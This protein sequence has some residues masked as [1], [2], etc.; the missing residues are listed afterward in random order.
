MN[1]KEDYHIYSHTN[2]TITTLGDFIGEDDSLGIGFNIYNLL[3]YKDE[4]DN[5]NIDNLINLYSKEELSKFNSL[6]QEIK[7]N[8]KN[9]VQDKKPNNVNSNVGFITPLHVTTLQTLIKDNSYISYTP[10]NTNKYFLD[11]LYNDDIKNLFKKFLYRV[12]NETDYKV[13]IN[14]SLRTVTEQQRQKELGNSASDFSYHMIGLAIDIR[15]ENRTTPSI[16]ITKSSLNTDWIKSGVVKIANQLNLGWG[17]TFSNVN[18]DPV[19][20]E[21]KYFFKVDVKKFL[22]SNGVISE[23]STVSVEDQINTNKDNDKYFDLPLK[24]GTVLNLPLKDIDRDV[25]STETNQVINS[26]DY[27]CF[28]AKELVGLLSDV[29]YK[30]TF[31]PKNQSFTGD[32]KQIFPYI[33]VW[34]WSRSLSISSLKPVNDSTQY[35]HQILNI[36]PYILNLNTTVSENGGNFS[37]NLSSITADI[38]YTGKE[39]IKNWSVKE[40]S[41]KVSQTNKNNYVNQGHLHY[42]EDNELKRNRMYFDKIIQTNDIVFIR[43]EKLELED[44]RTNFDELETIS[45]N[46]LP[47]QIFDM[48]ALVDDIQTTNQFEN[49][50]ANISVSGRDL[51]KLLI[52]DGVYFYPTEATSDGIFANTGATNTRLKR[53][54]PSGEYLGRFQSANKTIAKSLK[55]LINNLGSIEICPGSLFDGYANSLANKNSTQVIDKRSRSFLL[56]IDADN[57]KSKKQEENAI[58][59]DSIIDKINRVRNVNKI[60]SGSTIEVFNAIKIFLQDRITN[61][62]IVIIGQK[63]ISWKNTDQGIIYNNKLPYTLFNIFIKSNRIWIDKKDRQIFNIALLSITEYLESIYNKTNKQNLDESSLTIF[64]YLSYDSSQGKIEDYFEAKIDFNNII[65][66]LNTYIL[67]DNNM[68][69]DVIDINNLKNSYNIIQAKGDFIKLGI[70]ST[71]FQDLNDLEKDVFNDIYNLILNENDIQKPD[72]QSGLLA[73][74]WQII[75]LVIDDSVAD[76]RLT[77]SSIG[78]ENGSLLNAIRKICQDPFC[79]FYTD[80]Y[81]SQFYFIV[82]KKPFDKESILSILEGRAIFENL[83]DNNKS[84]T[85]ES[86]IF[87]TVLPV[88][89]DS[90]TIVKQRLIIDI[91]ESD[92]ISDSLK[93]SNEVYSWYK[94]QLANLTTGTSTDMAFA[95]LKAIYFNEF[96]DMYGSKPL[97]LTTSYIPYSPIIDKNKSLPTAYFIRQGVYDLKY[98][99]ESHAHLPFTR[100]GS[101]VMNG[102]RRI[103]K[104]NF[105]R[106]KSTNEIFYVDAVNNSYSI[107]NSSIDRTT[108]IQ[109][110]R[111]MVERFIKGVEINIDNN[112]KAANSKKINF[113]YF[114]ICDLSI[115]ESIFTN[116]NSNPTDF[117]KASTGNWKV[118]PEVFNFFLKKLQFSKND[119]E[120]ANINTKL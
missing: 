36:T 19:H 110:S 53:F 59:K 101:I 11:K 107:N 2:P 43:F 42:I 78:N 111:G 64:K 98:M 62:E 45:I 114:N 73:G 21:A 32:V 68:L 75:K 90:N 22:E 113:S 60:D 12:E 33:S 20:F 27:G 26:V 85:I 8:N 84:G 44:N 46:D 40:G 49:S 96:A 28:L 86:D 99:I 6:I 29:G 37:I 102:E 54:G 82:R 71:K 104:G 116:P 9:S 16:K 23:S 92:I 97:D 30:K 31:I 119:N 115:D 105:V 61:N 70:L 87:G 77:D 80:T 7:S 5:L 48:I 52:E 58:N 4:N 24:I 88:N 55:F 65:S 81:G 15:L 10:S 79:E 14:N 94:L 25:L 91:E 67:Y 51:V 103:K 66:E 18:P 57:I 112:D 76:R 108:S 34:L 1:S 100:M 118:N 109:V 95:Y 106:L 117:S 35:E 56:N 13:I 74:I 93:Y 3:N 50:D 38:R 72:E 41:Q 120:I 69:F 39:N 83:S 89:I 63:I 47:N 17:G